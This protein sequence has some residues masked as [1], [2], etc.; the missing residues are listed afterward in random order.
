MINYFHFNYV[1]GLVI[2]LLTGTAVI[3]TKFLL[4]KFTSPTLREGTK[5]SQQA[6]DTVIETIIV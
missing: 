2:F 6:A 5:N 4:L 1:Q 3:E